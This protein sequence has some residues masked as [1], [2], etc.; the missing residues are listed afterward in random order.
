MRRT[1]LHELIGADHLLPNEQQA[2]VA[3]YAA[4]GRDG[5]GE[6]LAP[7]AS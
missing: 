1:G 3:I 7:A 4:L 2:L 6:L 5:R